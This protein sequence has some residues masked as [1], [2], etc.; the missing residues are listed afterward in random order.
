MLSPAYS[1]D[2]DDKYSLGSPA[3][4]YSSSTDT[5]FMEDLDTEQSSQLFPELETS[6]TFDD[7]VQEDDS[8]LLH[9]L[10]DAPENA[11]IETEKGNNLSD[12]EET[13]VDED[14]LGYL[15]DASGIVPEQ[16][17][18]SEKTVTSTKF[19]IMPRKAEKRPALSVTTKRTSSNTRVV[20]VVKATPVQPVDVANIPDILAR[21]RH[22]AEMA[23]LNRQKKK[24]YMQ[25]LES[26]VQS[27]RKENEALILK[28]KRLDEDNV[29]LQEEVAYLKN[30]LANQS[31]LANILQNMDSVKGVTLTSSFTTKRAANLDH[32]Y[33]KPSKRARTVAPSGGIC[34][35]VDKDNV[36]L[37]FCPKCALMASGE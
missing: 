27:L 2:C 7:L 3:G 25:G 33:R 19:T 35:H 5:G 26:E 14:F 23:K 30:V 15:C 16:M 37:E 11:S 36:S 12:T 21:N 28:S 9:M 4:S 29:S 8:H 22:N 34:L 20:Q 24:A 31:V 32:D 6:I 1:L 17:Q 10:P 18:K 13:K